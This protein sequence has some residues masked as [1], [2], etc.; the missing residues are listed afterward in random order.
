M[1]ILAIEG[2]DALSGT[3]SDLGA[4]TLTITGS[5]S[6][7][8]SLNDPGRFG[9]KCLKTT[10]NNMTSTGWAIDLK[11]GIPQDTTFWTGFAFKL[12]ATGSNRLF[13]R[14]RGSS[15]LWSTFLCIRD[16][17]LVAGSNVWNGNGAGEDNYVT[18]GPHGMAVGVWY[19]W[20][21]E[22]TLNAGEAGNMKVW[23]DGNLLA[24]Q[25]FAGGGNG[26][27][28]NT[29]QNGLSPF[30]INAVG[31]Y[32]SNAT[33]MIEGSWDDLYVST[34]GRLGDV[35]V[36][37]LVP[38]SDLNNT[39]T[40]PSGQTDAY[41]SLADI[42]ASMDALYLT[43][44]DGDS[45]ELGFTNLS[46]S[47]QTVHAIGIQTVG[48]KTTANNVALT[49]QPVGETLASAGFGLASSWTLSTHVYETVGGSPISESL[50]NGLSLTLAVTDIT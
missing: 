4:G 5:Y 48:R 33:R 17:L 1:A 21:V 11:D 27:I 14:I 47:P 45:V 28:W 38:D 50:V 44:A 31:V 20:E 37:T 23:R 13:W 25:N 9:G 6:W 41:P 10:N 2:F 7:A 43:G 49:V 32:N 42:S 16:N 19:Y 15:G 26:N 12:T 34:T 46:T 30:P 24:D 3:G 35:R 39:M 18:L 36:E 22:V 40:L 8:L 29:T